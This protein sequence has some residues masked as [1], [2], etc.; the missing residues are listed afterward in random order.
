MN[1][2]LLWAPKISDKPYVAAV[3][4]CGD[5]DRS[6]K[7]LAEL[8]MASAQT[9]HHHSQAVRAGVSEM[10]RARGGQRRGGGL[11]LARAVLPS[12][13]SPKQQC[14]AAPQTHHRCKQPNRSQGAAPRRR[15][16][17][18]GRR[19]P[20]AS[21]HRAGAAVSTSSCNLNV[22]RI[23]TFTRW[24]EPTHSARAPSRGV[25]VWCAESKR[26]GAAPRSRPGQHTD[27]RS[28]RAR[29]AFD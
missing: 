13:R 28:M 24:L 23:A 8:M 26:L 19:L 12:P 21:S 14:C 4:S 29:G 2:P 5:L 16:G 22:D 10:G 7:K 6:Q 18:V 20:P 27:A 25:R 3:E 9:S 15:A 17:A 1:F 11:T